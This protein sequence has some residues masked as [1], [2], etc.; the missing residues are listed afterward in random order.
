METGSQFFQMLEQLPYGVGLYTAGH[1]YR[2][3]YLNDALFRLL[4]YSNREYAAVSHLPPE[5]FIY[6][7]D[8]WLYKKT[9]RKCGKRPL[10]KT[11]N[12]VLCAGIKAC[13]GYS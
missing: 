11:A 3:L 10:W 6:Y 8:R 5:S 7:E 4:G 12:A 1:E 13:G 9:W 2:V